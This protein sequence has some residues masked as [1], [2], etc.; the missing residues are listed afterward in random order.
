MSADR[1][2]HL[3][4]IAALVPPSG[5]VPGIRPR[6]SEVLRDE[7]PGCNPWPTVLS[8]SELSIAEVADNAEIADSIPAE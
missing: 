1:S 5:R 8:I 2:K 3:A 4:G 7:K 6:L